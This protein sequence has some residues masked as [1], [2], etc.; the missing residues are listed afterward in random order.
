VNVD[1]KHEFIVE[2]PQIPTISGTVDFDTNYL[3][4]EDNYNLPPPASKTASGG[5]SRSGMAD[6]ES[7]YQNSPSEE[8]LQINGVKYVQY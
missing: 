3:G 8:N 4:P 2:A 6:F 1:D 5:D 7:S